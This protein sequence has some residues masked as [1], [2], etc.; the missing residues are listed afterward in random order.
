MIENIAFILE[1]HQNKNIKEAEGE[2]FELLKKISL[3]SVAQ[4]R[5][6][7]CTSLE[8]FYVMFLRALVFQ[9]ESIVINYLFSI[10]EDLENIEIIISTLEK[11][12]INKK[13]IFIDTVKNEYFYGKLNKFE[14]ES[15]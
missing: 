6:D 8:I 10:V 14:N 15:K 7:M 4:K 11:L 1:V 2:V 5:I 12:D 3:T 9:S 13:I